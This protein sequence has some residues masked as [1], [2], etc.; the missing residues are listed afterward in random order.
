VKPAVGEIIPK[1]S[2][3]M[4]ALIRGE[5]K[6]P[7][8]MF[9][10]VGTGKTYAAVAALDRFGGIYH[11]ASGLCEML[12]V[13]DQ[14]GIQWPGGHITNLQT[15]EVGVWRSQ[16]LWNHIKAHQLVVLDEL[17]ARGAA[18]HTQRERIQTVMDLREGRPLILISNCGV[19]DLEHYYG[20]RIVSRATRGTVIEIAGRDRRRD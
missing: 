18:T 4:R 10:D 9:G 20:D 6:W 15:P 12:I 11:T 17:G 7:L 16:H 2:E 5:K 3:A 19:K 14:Q 1:F 8:L 13:A